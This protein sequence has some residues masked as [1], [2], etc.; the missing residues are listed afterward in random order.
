M[1]ASFAVGSIT[2]DV[3][4]KKTKTGK[5]YC[6]FSVRLGTGDNAEFASVKAWGEKAIAASSLKKGDSVI[7]AGRT[8]SWKPNDGGEVRYT[9]VAEVICPSIGNSES[10]RKDKPQP[11]DKPQ[12]QDRQSA[13]YDS[14]SLPF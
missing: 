9:L 10:E 8:E 1:K 14:D 6:M 13:F 11:K 12:E 4:L 2:K 5:T 3:E 7:V